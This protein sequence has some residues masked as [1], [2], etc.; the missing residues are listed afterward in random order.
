MSIVLITG[1]SR[2]IGRAAALA[3]ADRGFD[4]IITYV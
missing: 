2:G 1:G 4:T 3:F